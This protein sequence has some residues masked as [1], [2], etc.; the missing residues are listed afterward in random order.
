MSESRAFCP[1]CQCEVTFIRNADRATC[2]Q[3]GFVYALMASAGAGRRESA[4]PVLRIVLIVFLIMIALVVVGVA[5]VFAG[6]AVIM[7]GF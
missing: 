6:C 7:K 3:C 4:T 2:P 5:V 1:Q